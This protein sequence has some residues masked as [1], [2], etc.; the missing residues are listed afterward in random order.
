MLEKLV[1]IVALLEKEC[2]LSPWN[3]DQIENELK[4]KDE[5]VLL[6]ISS[7]GDIYEKNFPE[8][9]MPIGY[10]IASISIVDRL[11]EIRR[12]GVQSDNRGKGFAGRLLEHLETCIVYRSVPAPGLRIILEVAE[13]NLSALRLYRRFG[14]LQISVRKKYYPDGAAALILEKILE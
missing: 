6:F 11:C 9:I 13:N 3:A 10:C 2:F 5:T 4:K 7:V 8:N 12:I 14:F 1:N